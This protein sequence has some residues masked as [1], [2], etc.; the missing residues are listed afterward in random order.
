[1][2]SEAG[3]V[4]GVI[5]AVA[6]ELAPIGAILGVAGT[7]ADWVGGK[8]DEKA[9]AEEQQQTYSDAQQKQYMSAPSVKQS[10]ATITAPSSL[11]RVGGQAP[12]SSY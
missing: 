4:A 1:V 12:T 8:K 9:T 7:I 3:D 11:Q 6:P 5:S 2:L 10:V